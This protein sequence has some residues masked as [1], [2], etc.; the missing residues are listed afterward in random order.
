MSGLSLKTAKVG[1]LLGAVAAVHATH[2]DVETLLL[3][4]G[5]VSAVLVW[6]ALQV[7]DYKPNR[8]LRGDNSELRAENDE[9]RRRLDE[10]EAR[11]RELEK[12]RDFDT[13]FA[14]VMKEIAAARAQAAAE[15]RAILEELQESRKNQHETWATFHQQLASLTSAI[16]VVASGIL[17]DAQASAA[18]APVPQ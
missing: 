9:L 7:R 5:F 18:A 4:G 10:S 6:V 12:S 8:R 1:S 16:Q 15:H 2:S 3:V 17:S 11:Q 14:V 13:S